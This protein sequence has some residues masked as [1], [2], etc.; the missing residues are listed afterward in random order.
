MIRLARDT[1]RVIKQN[2]FWAFA[3]N[4]V[5]IP[6]AATGVIPP[7]YAAAAM[8]ASSISVVLNSLR[9]RKILM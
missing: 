4:A 8:M 7:R 3:Y 2:L 6:L 1:S 9:L 5:G